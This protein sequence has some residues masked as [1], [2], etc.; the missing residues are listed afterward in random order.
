MP[1]YIRTCITWVAVC[2]PTCFLAQACFPANF[3]ARFPARFPTRAYLPAYLP[4]SLAAFLP[5]RL[6][7][8]TPSCPPPSPLSCPPCCSSSFTFHVFM[9]IKNLHQIDHQRTIWQ[10]QN[11]CGSECVHPYTLHPTP[12]LLLR[13]PSNQP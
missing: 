10:L 3:P 11:C 8:Y 12:P 5:A 1:V 2:L 13:N 6:P 7:S 9:T 4:A